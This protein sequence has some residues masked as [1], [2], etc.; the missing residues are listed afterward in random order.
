[1]VAGKMAPERQAGC[2]RSNTHDSKK[3]R[4][5]S[6]PLSNSAPADGA[7]GSSQSST[8]SAM[9]DA[10]VGAAAAYYTRLEGDVRRPPGMSGA[11]K[12]MAKP[13]GTKRRIRRGSVNDNDRGETRSRCSL[14]SEPRQSCQGASTHSARWAARGCWPGARPRGRHRGA[15]LITDHLSLPPAPPRP[16]AQSSARRHRPGS[17]NLRTP[18]KRPRPHSS[19]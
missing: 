7:R 12:K 6:L 1:M 2:R 10:D 15:A 13:G 16:P 5:R 8:P 11:P 14:R 9:R 4:R 3:L 17:M 19:T 18:T